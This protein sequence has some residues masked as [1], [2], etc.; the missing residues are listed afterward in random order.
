M[1]KIVIRPATLA[2]AEDIVARL[3]G[4]DKLEKIGAERVR[5]VHGVGYA[6]EPAEG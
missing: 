5:T 1:T 3:R 2:D 6:F 4:I